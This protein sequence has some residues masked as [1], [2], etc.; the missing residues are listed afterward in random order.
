MCDTSKPPIFLLLQS[1][2]REIARNVDYNL[3]QSKNIH[4]NFNRATQ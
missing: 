3:V 2:W 4:S 1:F